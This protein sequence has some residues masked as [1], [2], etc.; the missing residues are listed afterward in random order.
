MA[1][2]SLGSAVRRVR[3][4]ASSDRAGVVGGVGRADPPPVVLVHGYLDTWRAP[5]WSALTRRLVDAGWSRDR[6]YH[7]DTGVTVGSPSEYAED[8]RAALERAHD[9]HGGPAGLLCHSMGG[10]TARWCIERGDG[11]PYVR[12][13]VTVATPH[14]GT[15]SGYLAFLTAGG[16]S[17]VPDSSFI[18]RLNRDGLE[19][20]VRYTAIGSRGDRLIVPRRS[21]FIP[22]GLAHEDTANVGIDSRRHVRILQDPRAV[23]EYVERLA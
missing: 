7:V 13:L 15:Y 8:V 5:W 6:I 20:S 19:P 10:L 16:R 3:H 9:A 12:D 14:R 2:G 22:D 1:L 17:M 11:A 18:R 4:A 21:A 23:S